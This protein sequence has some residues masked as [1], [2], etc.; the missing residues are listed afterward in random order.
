M[1]IQRHGHI[2]LKTQNEDKLS[3]TQKTKMVSITEST[4][5]T[6]RVFV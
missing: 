5:K 4:I 1:T 3:E 2:R 6:E